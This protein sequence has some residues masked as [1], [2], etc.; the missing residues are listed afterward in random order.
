MQPSTPPARQIRAHDWRRGVMG[1]RLKL[2]APSPP[3]QPKH[4]QTDTFHRPTSTPNPSTTMR[5]AA[6]IASLVLA[7]TGCVRY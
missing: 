5:V 6:I 7:V 2:T 4:M 3:L 1:R